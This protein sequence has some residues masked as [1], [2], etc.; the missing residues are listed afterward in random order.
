MYEMTEMMYH[1]CRDHSLLEEYLLTKFCDL[2]SFFFLQLSASVKLPSDS[3][4]VLDLD[5]SHA[6]VPAQ[7]K[8]VIMSTKVQCNNLRQLLKHCTQLSLVGV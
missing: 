8:T 3:E 5:L 7:C 6:I 1:N 4:F 2:T